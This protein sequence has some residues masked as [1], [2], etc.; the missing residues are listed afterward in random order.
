MMSI[1]PVRR[2]SWSRAVHGPVQKVVLLTI[3]LGICPSADAQSSQDSRDFAAW[4]AAVQSHIPGAVD[5]AVARV[6]PWSRGQLEAL[7]PQLSRQRPD[8]RL[9]LVERAL[10][11]HTD[12]AIQHRRPDGYHGVPPTLYAAMMFRDGQ[13]TGQ[14]TGTFHWEFAR[15]LIDRLS[16]T[17]AQVRV[18]RQFYRATGAL[19]Q[20]WREY[21]E[22]R[23]HLASARR[24]IG[25]D[26]VLLMYEGTFYQAHAAP[27]MQRFFDDQ[28]RHIIAR[29]SAA[30]AG[31]ITTMQALIPSV[32]RRPSVRDIRRQAEVLFRQAIALDPSLAEA[33]IRLAHVLADQGEH[34]AAQETLVRV[35]AGPLPGRLEYYAR[36]L[37]G[38][39]ARARND[40]D[41]AHAAFERASAI[42]PDASTPLYALSELAIARGDNARGLRYL[43]SVETHTPEQD[44]WWTFD[45][46]HAPSADVLI[47]QMRTS[48][49]P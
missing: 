3:L 35:M 26:P 42:V 12:I 27:R 41:S 33:H 7:L 30:S 18:G 15:K 13:V 49:T 16:R 47:E 39:L 1:L 48:V 10:V 9:R 4:V 6:A 32:D 21:S 31:G 37:D 28:E 24:L 40:L 20:Q 29:E 14:T 17:D 38:R 23:L 46:I 19:L 2:C 25:E 43:Q 34:D 5:E 36:L 11:L 45:R 8:E 44:P 22:L